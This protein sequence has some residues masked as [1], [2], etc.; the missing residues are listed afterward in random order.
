MTN[1]AFSFRNEVKPSQEE[2]IRIIKE[3]GFTITPIQE[4]FYT[5]MTELLNG[6]REVSKI[7]CI[8]A[9][10]G[11][12]KSLLI[13]AYSKWCADNNEGLIVVTDNLKR[14]NDIYCFDEKSKS[15]IFKCEAETS[16]LGEQESLNEK[17]VVLLTTQKYF[18]LEEEQRKILFDFKYG[19]FWKYRTRV[20]FDELPLF[21]STN[22]I[23][24][25]ELNDIDTLIRSGLDETIKDKDEILENFTK[26]RCSLLAYME[27]LEKKFET[28][29]IFY[30]NLD[31][32]NEVKQAFGDFFEKIDKHKTLLMK[33]DCNYTKNI[34]F[35]NVLCSEGGFFGSYKKTSGY[36]YSNSFFVYKSNMDY[37]KTEK[38]RTKFFVF[39]ATSD[40]HPLYRQP[41]ISLYN[42]QKYRLPLNLTIKI[43]N[44]SSSKNA[45]NQEKVIDISN[46]IK[47]VKESEQ[48]LIF[49]YKEY[50]KHFTDISTNVSHFG[51]I[52][53]YNEYRDL[54][55]CFQVG[56]N[57]FNPFEYFLM[58]G[59]VTDEYYLN[60]IAMTPERSVEFFEGIIKTN[61]N[62]GGAMEAIIKYDMRE[63]LI[64]SIVADFEQNIFRMSIRNIDNQASNIAYLFMNYETETYNEIAKCIEERFKG[65]ANIEYIDTPIN[66]AINKLK[67]RKSAKGE[68]NTQKVIA[69]IENLDDGEMFRTSDL[70]KE[71]ELSSKQLDKVKEHNESIRS[72]FLSM[73]TER[74]G[75]Y[76]KKG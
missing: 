2:I 5:E 31:E 30:A 75:W 55:E 73:K 58:A 36:K 17:A 1:K 72:L 50:E 27:S 19:R 39:D 29:A 38:D 16:I 46:Y 43:V 25:K 71:T 65:I 34:S 23:G 8:P 21:Y 22:E 66:I 60:A 53:G 24:V 48:P 42:C 44:I 40:I 76:V 59:T 57:R 35:L 64:N 74:K 7:T 62:K 4:Q 10:C 3:K 13:S 45:L 6:D 14:L 47:R 26:G 32:L 68:T 67:K 15:N 37:F 12:G 28:D 51:N 49:T 61:S 20:I 70:L 11:I 56:I 69:W 18:G 33:K 54:T 41:F 52:K 9:R 63:M